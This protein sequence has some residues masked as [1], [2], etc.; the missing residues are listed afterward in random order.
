MT[1]R[2]YAVFRTKFREPA[3]NISRTAGCDWQEQISLRDRS[4]S[5]EMALAPVKQG[6]PVT[7]VGLTVLIVNVFIL[8]VTHPS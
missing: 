5:L 6:Q 8:S 3:G 7:D 1:R 4:T 2:S